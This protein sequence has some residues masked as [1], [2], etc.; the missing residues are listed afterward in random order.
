MANQS[1]RQVSSSPNNEAEMRSRIPLDGIFAGT[2]GEVTLAVWFLILDAVSGHPFYTPRAL[3]NVFYGFEEA[4]PSPPDL[5]TRLKVVGGF[6]WVHWLAFVLLGAF[7][8]WLLATAEQD[9]NVGF[10]ILLFF[11]VF[12]FGSMGFVSM[13]TSD[14]LRLHSGLSILVGNLLAALAMAAYFWKRHPHMQVNP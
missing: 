13:V 14:I 7:A 9:P 2:L 4:I 11:V 5:H 1:T 12:G 10:G 8:S 6:L 3:V